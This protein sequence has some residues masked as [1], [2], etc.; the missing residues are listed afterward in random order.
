MA[1]RLRRTIGFIFLISV[2]GCARPHQQSAVHAEHVEYTISLR[3]N[4]STSVQ[5]KL[6][7]RGTPEPVSRFAIAP[8][9]GGTEN[10]ERF[11]HDLH[12]VDDKGQ[13]C[14]VTVDPNRPHGWDVRHRPGALLTVTC[15]LKPIEPDPLTDFKTHY[16][17]VLRPDL[18]HLIGE[19]ALIYPEWLEDRGVMDIDFQTAGFDENG[20]KLATSFDS[21]KPHLRR[22]LQQFRHGLFFAGR[23]QLQDVEV[24]GGKLRVGVYGDDW[25]FTELELV[26]LVKRIISV[27][28][29]FVNDFTDPYFLVTVVPTGPRATPQS[30]SL[31]G[32]GL[33]NCF[34]MFL[35]PGMAIGEQS[36]HRSAFLRLLAHEYFHTWNGGKLS[37]EEPEEFVYWFSEGFTDYY[38]SRILRK[39]GFLSDQEWVDRFNETL[40][41]LYLSPVSTAPAETIRKDFWARQEVQKLPYNRGEVVAYMLDQEIRKKSGNTKNLDDFMRELFGEAARGEKSQTDRLLT[42][43]AQWTDRGFA[44]NLRKVVMDGQL[45]SP[46]DTGAD[47]NVQKEM[48]EG[49]RFEP[50]FDVDSTFQNK[51]VAGVVP[52]SKAYAAGLRDGQAIAGMSVTRGDSTRLIELTIR[53]NDEK[54]KIS[55]LPHG[56]AIQVPQ[57]K[58]VP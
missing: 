21:E 58:L 2:G 50:G 57:Y 23:I 30:L 24:R 22:T 3:T 34:A 9:W 16:E 53:E 32:T 45:P 15:D 12:V 29:E 27:E 42:R 1:N 8:S 54:R 41:N 37:T 49:H 28:R 26:D 6:K 55:Y 33:T 38:A 48:I 44:D 11:V 52:N 40:R 18:L 7:V 17:P 36:P 47:P 51:K 39:G 13:E 20:W 43:V 19:T 56:E 31:G 4:P 46:P 5:I 14:P 25:P 35:A 10:C